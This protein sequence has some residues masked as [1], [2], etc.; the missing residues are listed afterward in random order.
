M[1]HIDT[2]Y[3]IATAAIAVV[4]FGV[5]GRR[6]GPVGTVLLIVAT[7]AGLLALKPDPRRS[8][9]PSI[10]QSSNSP[11]PVLETN[12]IPAHGI[13]AKIAPPKRPSSGPHGEFAGSSSCREC[14][15]RQYE[16]WHDSY[17]RTMT[18]VVSPAT[19][20]GDFSS[21]RL[22]NHASG[23][24]VELGRHGDQFTFSW[25]D[26]KTGGVSPPQALSLSTGSHHM[27]AYWYSVALGDSLG[28][29]PFVYLREEQRWAPREA[30]FVGPSGADF[31]HEIGR[32]NDVCFNCH[33]TGGE[34]RRVGESSLHE[35]RVAEFGIACE[36][37]HGAA[38]AHVAFRRA[39]EKGTDANKTDPILNPAAMSAK[40]SIEMCG[41]CHR[42]IT[43]E[44]EGELIGVSRQRM[45]EKASGASRMERMSAPALRQQVMSRDA[46]LSF[47]KDGMVRVAGR[48]CNGVERAPCHLKGGMSCVDCHS[49]HRE[50]GDESPVAEWANDQL[51]TRAVSDEAC[52]KCHDLALFSSREHTRHAPESSGSRCYNCHMPHTSYGL[53]KA[54]RSHLI[55]RPSATETVRYGRQN[56]C[57]VCH[58]DRSLKWTADH[59]AEWYG[60]ERP[61]LSK[62]QEAFSS[63]ALAALKGDGV[64]RVL[65]AWHLGWEPAIQAS[66]GEWAPGILTILMED[67]Y[68]AVRFVAGRSLKRWPG[69]AGIG[70]DYVAEKEERTK[71]VS[72]A[73]E[74]WRKRSKGG[75]GP[76]AASDIERLLGG[77]DNTIVY[78]PE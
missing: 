12:F 18:Q 40:Q 75:E 52:S 7:G 39:A 28:M 77:R 51:R 2:S 23:K 21:Q 71:A 46:E 36:S 35:T 8:D 41:R 37:C 20:I 66:G 57:N 49:L 13:A 62:D 64:D 76:I 11:P 59:M 42:A 10:K 44:N 27:Q 61:T 47:W 30:V 48:E 5:Y 53:L 1:F 4:L 78:L 74:I 6:S 32:W 73:K 45:E 3:L 58:I 63:V 70:F 25:V 60:V 38:S 67:D 65:A 56:A 14:H 16:T 68:Q 69:Y 33:A 15:G 43:F 54:T 22:T 9:V 26:G 17:H 50:R 24:V 29:M 72:A 55:S 34:S 19:V 31:G